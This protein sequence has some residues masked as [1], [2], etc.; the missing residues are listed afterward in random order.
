MGVGLDILML[1]LNAEREITAK[2]KIKLFNSII[3]NEP[4]YLTDIKIDEG[5]D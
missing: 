3:T 4:L 2:E 1:E 5:R